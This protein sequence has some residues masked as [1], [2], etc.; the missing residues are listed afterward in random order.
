MEDSHGPAIP[1]VVHTGP[2]AWYQNSPL[3]LRIVGALIIGVIFGLKVGH[4]SVH[5]AP[6][7]SVVLRLLGALATPLIF[8]AV[9][10]ALVKAKISGRTGAKL[11]GQLFLNTTV[12]ILVGLLIANT[13]RPGTHTHVDVKLARPALEPFDPIKDL[14]GKIPGSVLKPLS[15]NDIMGVIVIALAVGAGLR[16]V[17]EQVED[18][19]SERTVIRLIEGFLDA[20]FRLIMVVLHWVLEL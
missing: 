20:A 12:A 17:R 1:P 16:K 18:I 8:I 14:L 15:E 5:L 13:L 10:R 6:F 2:F 19:E 7:S 11:V 3:Y 9:I 4:W